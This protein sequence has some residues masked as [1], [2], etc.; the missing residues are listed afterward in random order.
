MCTIF[1]I[2]E[3]HMKQWMHRLL[4]CSLITL[5]LGTC[6]CRTSSVQP[7]QPTTQTVP[8]RELNN[9]FVRNDAPKYGLTAAISTQ[10]HFNSLFG[11][12]AFMGPKGMPSAIDFDNEAVLAV[13]TRPLNQSCTLAVKD[14][15]KDGNTLLFR[16]TETLGEPLTYTIRPCLLIAI[17]K[18]TLESTKAVHF[19]EVNTYNKIHS[20]S[21]TT[22]SKDK[23]NFASPTTVPIPREETN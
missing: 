6:A 13:T 3:N 1:E 4:F 9:Y 5:L 22:I 21:S 12:A 11:M 10:D 15:I 8:F 7:A 23:P 2:K 19:E 14:V 18:A 16:F 20:P 17:P